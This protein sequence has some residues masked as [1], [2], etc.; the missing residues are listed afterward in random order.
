MG[1]MSRRSG[2]RRVSAFAERE[3][4]LAGAGTVNVLARLTLAR[5]S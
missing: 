3:S 1:F 2:H 5:L 4:R